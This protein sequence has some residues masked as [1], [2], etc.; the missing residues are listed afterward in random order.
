MIEAREIAGFV[1]RNSQLYGERNSNCKFHDIWC[2]LMH[3]WVNGAF[4]SFRVGTTE[5]CYDILYIFCAKN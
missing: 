1:W 3:K 5:T 2:R 4:P